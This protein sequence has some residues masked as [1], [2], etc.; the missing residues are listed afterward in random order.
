L[1]SIFGMIL[2]I[3]F[4]REQWY[5]WLA[6]NIVSVGIYITLIVKDPSDLPSI[7]YLVMWAFY[8]INSIIGIIKW[9]K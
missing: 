5:V 2:M 4:Y 9:R 6:V 3:K 7:L 8:I 1:L